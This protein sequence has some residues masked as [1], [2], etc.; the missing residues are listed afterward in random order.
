MKR[1]DLILSVLF[2]TAAVGC[3]S[4]RGSS[5]FFDAGPDSD[6]DTGLSSSDADGLSAD[7]PV[8]SVTCVADVL[9]DPLNCGACGHQ[10]Q[11]AN[12]TS[13]C[14]M[15][16]CEFTCL[17][18][19]DD[20]EKADPSCETSL[21]VPSSCGA[22]NVTCTPAAPLCASVGNA[23][24]CVLTCDATTPD[25]CGQKC[26]NLES[27]AANCGVCGTACTAANAAGRCESRSCKY[28]CTAGFDNCE[29]TAPDCET[30]IKGNDANN[31][32]ECG[33]KCGGSCVNGA[34][35]GCTPGATT[36]CASQGAKG[37]CGT[38]IQTCTSAGTWGQC[39][40]AA[41]AQDS[42]VLGNDD[43]CD[44]VPNSGCTCDGFVMSNHPGTGGP[45]IP[46]YDATTQGQVTDSVS[47]LVWQ[48]TVTGTSFAI[49]DAAEYCANKGAGWHLPN[50]L[51]LISLVDLSR[52]DPSI[53]PVAFPNAPNLRFWTSNRYVDEANSNWFVQFDLGTP[54]TNVATSTNRVRCVKAPSPRCYRTGQRFEV[55]AGGAVVDNKTG[56][57]WQQGV[58]PLTKNWTDAKSYCAG[59][60]AGFRLPSAKEALTII[61]YSKATGTAMIDLTAFPGTPAAAFWTA[62]VDVKTAGNAWNVYVNY[63]RLSTD[64]TT[65][66]YQVRCVK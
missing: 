50:L 23:N 16:K 36:S 48:Q 57:T 39:S 25:K 42:C 51:E 33:K 14:K 19:F 10:C 34:C 60:G 7:A 3:G 64:K 43:T 13:S 56:L 65:S 12:A 18:R 46:T 9:N 41:A 27:D 66:A 55:V 32:G 24:Q 4:Q 2:L 61:D 63:G 26:V 22:C 58:S 21:S 44:G 31:C 5:S 8:D 20:C 17:P 35:L 40:V 28:I 38:G 11:A 49:E 37:T 53:D 15:G 29:K 6:A 45:N 54:S 59:L 52:V 30:F 62:S 47:R 1:V